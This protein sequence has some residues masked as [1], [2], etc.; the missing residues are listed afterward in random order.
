MTR[1]ISRHGEP[2]SL[3][4]HWTSHSRSPAEV[5]HASVACRG[6]FSRG[7][8]YPARSSQITCIARCYDLAG[9]PEL[10][11]GPAWGGPSRTLVRRRSWLTKPDIKGWPCGQPRLI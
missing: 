10:H 4:L 2:S 9:V 5:T 1:T 11:N 7:E 6:R 3:A 8:S